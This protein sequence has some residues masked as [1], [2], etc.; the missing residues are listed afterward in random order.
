MNKIKFSH[1][2]YKLDVIA[3]NASGGKHPVILLEVFSKHLEEL[4]PSFIKYDTSYF[5]GKNI[6]EYKLPNKGLIVLLF[7]DYK[8]N[9]FTTVRP[10][11]KYLQ[12]ANT[13]VDK[14]NYYMSKR[15]EEFEIV[16]TEEKQNET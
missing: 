14:Y 12:H 13:T 16:F 9:L 7:K 10:R 5:D 11:M 6:E 1:K 2:Y 8:G 3:D 15:G 4:H